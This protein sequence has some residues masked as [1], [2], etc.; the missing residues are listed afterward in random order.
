MLFGVESVHPRQG[1]H[2]LVFE[3]SLHNDFMLRP[4]RDR[5]VQRKRTLK[6]NEFSVDGVVKI[7]CPQI[8]PVG[9][10]FREFSGFIRLKF[11]NIER[12]SHRV[13]LSVAGDFMG[14]PHGLLQIGGGHLQRQ[15]VVIAARSAQRQ[16]CKQGRKEKESFHDTMN[17]DFT[18]KYNGIIHE[19]KKIS[20]CRAVARFWARC[21]PPDGALNG[22]VHPF[23]LS[24]SCAVY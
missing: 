3:E 22:G 20:F 12:F 17:V 10:H 2:E 14:I 24:E 6:L 5:P 4:F 16:A 1:H 15:V 7:A 18:G 13:S 11:E 21:D 9:I 19:S 8:F 23:G